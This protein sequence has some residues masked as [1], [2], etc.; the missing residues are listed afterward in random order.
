LFKPCFLQIGKFYGFSDG[1]LMRSLL[2]DSIYVS[3]TIEDHQVVCKSSD[4]EDSS[5]R[6]S[7]VV[8]SLVEILKSGIAIL[9]SHL[10]VFSLLNSRVSMSL[11][12]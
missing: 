1:D 4:N 8:P 9:R 2:L 3:R 7:F 5:A 11:S 6:S 12:D 10:V